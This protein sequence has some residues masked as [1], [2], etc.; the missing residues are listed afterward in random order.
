MGWTSTESSFCCSMLLLVLLVVFFAI[1]GNRCSTQMPNLV[2]NAR[3]S[4]VSLEGDLRAH[5]V[6]LSFK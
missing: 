3:T 4:G 5:P 2:V 6:P 1:Q